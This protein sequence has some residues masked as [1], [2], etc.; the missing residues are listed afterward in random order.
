MQHTMVG[1]VRML[2]NSN[3]IEKIDGESRYKVS[4]PSQL[5]RAVESIKNGVAR[6][7]GLLQPELVRGYN[8][9]MTAPMGLGCDGF[10]YGGSG[11]GRRQLVKS[12]N[13]FETI[14]PGAN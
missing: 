8:N 14:S 2:P 7:K 6:P 9:E 3:S 5:N 12:D 4:T 10:I 13:G 1:G 11:T